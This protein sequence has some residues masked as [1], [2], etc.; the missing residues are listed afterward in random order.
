[1]SGLKNM[2]A[3][4]AYLGGDNQ[5][6]RMQVDKVR[7]LRKALLYSYQ[8][9]TAILAD[10]REFRCL[11]NPNKINEN[12]DDKMISIP[13]ED[14]CLNKEKPEGE[15]T[16][17]GMESIGLKVGD[18]LTWKENDT[19]W[20]VYM[21][22][23]QETSYFRGLMRQCEDEPLD[24][25][26]G[27]KRWVYIK[28]PE[29]KS[30]DWQKT[31]RFMFNDLNYTLE[32]FVSKD[33]DTI[34]FF[35]RFK[36]LNFKGK[37]WEVQAIDDISMEGI[38]AVYLKEDYTNEFAAEAPRPEDDTHGNDQAALPRIQ[39]DTK[40][41]PFDIKEYVVEG[42]TG[43]H[44]SLSNSRATILEQNET[45]VKIEITTGRSGEIDLLYK[46]DHIKDIVFNIKILSL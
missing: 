14:I 21:R 11:I 5:K 36:K 25:G 34:E 41:Y 35:H 39:G 2:K 1:M 44:W 30:I 46:A 37:N 26:N 33:S 40:V 10:G 6:T 9:E 31:E 12:I 8:S 29:E 3:R 17:Q 7:S 42:A 45:S 32:M 28:G 13:Y 38:I 43:G 27:V 19:H 24:L 18:S 22:Y 4:I 23:L 15:T 16:T 20:I